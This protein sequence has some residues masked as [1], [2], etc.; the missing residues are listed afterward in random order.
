MVLTVRVGHKDE[1]SGNDDRN[2]D[3]CHDA[4]I[5]VVVDNWVAL[6]HRADLHRLELILLLHILAHLCHD[7][8]IFE[9]LVE[10]I[11]GEEDG[12]DLVRD[13]RVEE[14]LTMF[15]SVAEHH[16]EKEA[17][18]RDSE[19]HPDWIEISELV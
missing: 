7:I 14:V 2:E 18:A 10:L 15:G 5:S 8:L 1:V 11:V 4:L 6:L 19:H 3:E 16:V 17:H 9:H 13:V 12:G